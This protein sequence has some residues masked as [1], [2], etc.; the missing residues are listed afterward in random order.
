MTERLRMFELA[1]TALE[2]DL[3]AGRNM[4]AATMGLRELDAL[5]AAWKRNEEDRGG[6]VEL[7][8]LQREYLAMAVGDSN[9]VTRME[10]LGSERAWDVPNEA[11]RWA[12]SMG[13]AGD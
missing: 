7:A 3:E 8:R 2:R 4:S 12:E 6:V 10:Q 11:R 9:A 1:R 13:V 5:D